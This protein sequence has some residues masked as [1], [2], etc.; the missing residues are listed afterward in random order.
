MLEVGAMQHVPVITAHTGCEGTVHNSLESI[1]AGKSAGAD[2]VEV[3]IRATEDGV[4]VL[5]HDGV[6]R[7]RDGSEKPIAEMSLAEVRA[8]GRAAGAG[9]AG[10]PGP[11]RAAGPGRSRGPVIELRDA[12]ALARDEGVILNLDLKDDAGI[13]RVLAHLEEF[14][15]RDDVVFSGCSRR[16]AES[17]TSRLRGARVLLN[18]GELSADADRDSYRDF[19]I[20]NYRAAV[21]AG[22]CGINIDYRNCREELVAYAGRR[23]LP[24][25]VWTVNTVEEM[26]RMTELG[27]FAITTENPRVLSGLLNGA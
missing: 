10:E 23:L 18:A 21:E 5:L 8:V 27:V 11:G 15:M 16:R 25:S 26:R 1:T 22:C 4:P 17:I 12:L 20:H 7:L 2:A 24:V 6:V 3:D 9:S 13:P 19:V 14:G